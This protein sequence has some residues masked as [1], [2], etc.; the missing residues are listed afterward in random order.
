MRMRRVW[1]LLVLAAAAI[2]SGA[3]GGGEAVGRELAKAL[4]ARAPAERASAVDK[5]LRNQ[6]SADAAQAVVDAI[7]DRDEAQIVL[8]VAVTA[9]AFMKDEAVVG[10]LRRAADSGPLVQRLRAIETLGRSV[11][12]GAAP[13]LVTLACDPDAAIRAAAVTALGRKE[14]VVATDVEGALKDPA[15]AVR[16]A[17][18]STLGRLQAKRSVPALC[19]AM[20]AGD[21]RMVDACV[22]ALRSICGQRFGAEPERWEAWWAKDAGLEPPEAAPW[23]APAWTFQSPVIA[24]RSRRVRFVLSTSDT[25]KDPIG[26]AAADAEVLASI[27]RAGADLAEDLVAAKSKLDVARVHLRAMLRTLRDDTEF[28]VMTYSG[29]PAFAFG[30]LT[31]ADASSRK[32]AESRIASLSPGGTA[33]L[34]AALQRAFDPRGKDPL[35]VADGPDTIVLLGDGAMAEPGSTDATEVAGAPIRWNAVR[36]IRFLVVATGQADDAALGRLADGP[37]RG[38]S[39]SLP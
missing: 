2:A 11:A 7:F 15:P 39:A 18:A 27:R 8:D 22:V 13:S 29:S 36:Q 20:R 10:V 4:R 5:A 6:D 33:N 30:R 19:A 28:D 32:R 9:L 17:A 37:P 38:A 35:A 16:Y 24:T 25:M 14:A 31:R 12:D 23:A 3:P 21:G 34:Q 1:P 26:N